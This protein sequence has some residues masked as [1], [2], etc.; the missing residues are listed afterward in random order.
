[1]RHSIQ[2]LVATWERSLFWCALV[3]LLAFLLAW[4]VPRRETA[5]VSTP[6]PIPLRNDIVAARAFAMLAD[7][8]WA[9]TTSGNPFLFV[10]RPPAIHDGHGGGGTGGGGTGGGGTGGGG[11]GGGGTGGGGTGGGGTYDPPPTPPKSLRF[12]GVY[13]STEGERL[14]AIEIRDAVSGQSHTSFRRAGQTCEGVKLGRFDADSLEFL[15]PDGRRSRVSRGAEQN[16][17]TALPE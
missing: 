10:Y 1:M 15:S 3:A 17:S 11:T 2:A 4:Y 5:G 8:Q 7:G 9:N 13:V 16:L 14:A 6:Q 12:L